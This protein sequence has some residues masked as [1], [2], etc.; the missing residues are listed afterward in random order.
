LGVMSSGKEGEE[1]A[2]SVMREK[3]KKEIGEKEGRGLRIKVSKK[4][5]EGAS[6]Q[7]HLVRERTF[8]R[9]RR[10]GKKVEKKKLRGRLCG[11]TKGGKHLENAL[12]PGG[13]KWSKGR[14]KGP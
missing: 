6:S 5:R 14:E 7:E 9:K 3:E 1:G 4:A 13:R 8:F 11:R 2:D 12:G 10:K